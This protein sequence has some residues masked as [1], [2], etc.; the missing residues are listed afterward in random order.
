MLSR[1]SVGGTRLHYLAHTHR[2][3]ISNIALLRSEDR[4]SFR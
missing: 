2:V 3:A 4:V 1:L